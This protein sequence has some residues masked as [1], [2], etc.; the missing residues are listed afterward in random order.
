MPIKENNLI[1]PY[2]PSINNPNEESINYKKFYTEM[3]KSVQKYNLTNTFNAA[4]RMKVILHAKDN[5][6]RDVDNPV[7]ALL[8]AFTY[9]GVWVDDN[10]VRDL[11]II[12]GKSDSKGEGY[13]EVSMNEATDLSNLICDEVKQKI[14]IKNQ[15]IK[16]KPTPSPAAQQ[17]QKKRKTRLV[18]NNNHQ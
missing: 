1:F 5:T 3:G 17:N 13:I 18:I 2:P 7:K 11:R 16:N 15:K 6:K 14:K 10:Q 8:D 12:Y 9:A 4:V